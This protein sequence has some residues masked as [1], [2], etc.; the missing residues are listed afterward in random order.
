[1]LSLFS[2]FVAAMENLNVVLRRSTKPRRAVLE[3]GVFQ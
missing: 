3:L 2:G 1:M